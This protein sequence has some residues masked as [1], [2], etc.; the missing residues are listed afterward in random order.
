MFKFNKMACNDVVNDMG[1]VD[2]PCSDSVRI[3]SD[4]NNKCVEVRN[5]ARTAERNTASIKRNT[6]VYWWSY[7]SLRSCSILSRMEKSLPKFQPMTAAQ[8][9]LSHKSQPMRKPP[10]MMVCINYTTRE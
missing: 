6:S 3:N 10:I 7:K 2:S 1:E 8:I 4:T 9:D 5:N